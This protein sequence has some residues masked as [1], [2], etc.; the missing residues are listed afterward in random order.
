MG[1]R[2]LKVDFK[3][4][5]EGVKTK[6]LRC[7]VNVDDIIFT[8]EVRVNGEWA[9]QEKLCF[10]V[11]AIPERLVNGDSYASM[12]AYGVRAFISDRTSQFRE[13]GIPATMAGMREVYDLLLS[14]QYNAKRKVAGALN[15]DKVAEALAELKGISQAKALASLMALTK[16]KR[17]E[18]AANE[19]VVAIMERLAMDVMDADVVDLDDLY[20]D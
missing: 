3:M 1:C 11:N 14:G 6:Q 19:K 17:I 20:G 13:F 2:I 4:A 10:D 15:L 18:V 16:E 5:K 7:T 12:K 9:V 8:H